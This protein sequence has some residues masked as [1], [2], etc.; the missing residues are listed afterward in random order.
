MARA[1]PPLAVPSSLVSTTPVTPTA[2]AN[3]LAW[4]RPFCPVVASMTSSTSVTW[5][6]RALGHPAHLF[7]LLH[8]VDLGVEPAGGVGQHEVG[9]PGRGPLARRR[10]RP[11]PGRRP[12]CPRT[13]SA[14]TRL[15]HSSSWS[16]AAARKV[17]P[18]AMTTERPAAASRRPSLPMVVVLPTPLTPTNSH[19]LG[20]PGSKCRSRSPCEPVDEVGLR[21]RSTQL[22]G[23]GDAVLLDPAAQVVEHRG[24]RAD[25]DV[26]ADQRLL[27]VVPGL[28]VDPAAGPDRGQVAGEE[29]PGLAQPVPEPGLDRRRRLGDLGLGLELGSA[30]ASTRAGG[31]ARS[32]GRRLGGELGRRRSGAAPGRAGGG[33][34][35]AVRPT[36]A[37]A[38]A[39]RRDGAGRRRP[40]RRRAEPTT[41]TTSDDDQDD[42]DEPTGRAEPTGGRAGPAQTGRSG[43]GRRPAR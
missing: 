15:A 27:E 35:G 31:L 16:A 39:R 18:A 7:Q 9:L 36:A 34:A 38:R 30:A 8:Q 43:A 40:G 24:G 17:S 28:L 14:P 41:A 37:A 19:T 42:G 10:R 33:R 32:V 29:G 4:I 21:A 3:C 25:A 1:I 2:A 12:R 6:G 5:P 13:R 23:V 11:R 22:L 20:P 26:G